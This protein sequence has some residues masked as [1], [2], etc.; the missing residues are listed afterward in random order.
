LLLLADERRAWL[1]DEPD[2]ERDVLR[3]RGEED[4]R[5][6]MR[7]RL[8]DRHSSLTCNTP[9]LVVVGVSKQSL[10]SVRRTPGQK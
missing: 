3:D 9:R 10:A 2:R 4:V 7:L 1:P 8:R 5:V 6:A